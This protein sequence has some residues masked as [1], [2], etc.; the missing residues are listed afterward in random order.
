MIRCEC[1]LPTYREFNRTLNREPVLAFVRATIEG[2][3][4]DLTLLSCL[5]L[6]PELEVLGSN[7]EWRANVRREMGKLTVVALR[8]RPTRKGNFKRVTIG[9]KVTTS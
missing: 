1:N 3:K 8:L 5:E 2:K 4:R 7:G 6:D 9:R